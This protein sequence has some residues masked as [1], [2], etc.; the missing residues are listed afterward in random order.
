M[1][2]DDVVKVAVLL[3]CLAV[4]WSCQA[5]QAAKI[6]LIAGKVGSHATAEHEYLQGLQL[7]KHCLDTSSNLKGVEVEVHANGWPEDPNTLDDAD[8]IVFYSDGADYGEENC[9]FLAGDRLKAVDKQVGRGCGIVWMH[10]ATIVPNRFEDKWLRWTGGFFDYDSGPPPNTWHSRIK[11][12]TSCPV[13]A[14]P[15]HPIARGIRP[16]EIREEYYYNLRFAQDAEGW[17]PI[18]TTPL[19]GEAEPQVVAWAIER[20]DGGRGFGT[21]C[22]HTHAN[23]LLPEFR[24]M[25][26]NA[27]VWTAGMEVPAGGVE[28][29]LPDEAEWMPREKPATWSESSEEEEEEAEDPLRALIV[30]GDDQPGHN[31]RETSV[32]LRETLWRDPR[33]MVDMTHDPEMLATFDISPYDVIVLNYCNWESPGLSDTAKERFSKYVNN[34]GGLA[35][36]HLA[37]G[38][39][40]GSLPGAEESDWPEYRKICR[41]VWDCNSSSHG[42]YETFRVDIVNEDHPITADMKAF[43]A[44]DQ[45][46]CGLEGDLPVEVL[47]VAR[48]KETGR[49]EPMVWVNDYG[50]GRVFQTVLGHSAESLHVPYVTEL[51]RR[52][53]VWAAG[54]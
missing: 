13:L 14:T 34:G 49:D 11:W 20:E 32:V 3:L 35:V 7:F 43:E 26:L 39:W 31:W 40:H 15:D 51:I 47:A 17:A 52:G 30:T 6:V 28:S 10:Y 23:L 21:T 50:K 48:P 12:A 38:A 16:F 37:T 29:T 4:A 54:R 33:F 41:R 9:P 36:I 24:K 2:H 46:Y 5:V 19:P 1:K 45:L 18:W 44:V 42:E 27:I 8:T 53:C 22:G 25:H